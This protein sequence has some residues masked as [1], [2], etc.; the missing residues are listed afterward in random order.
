MEDQRRLH[1]RVGEEQGAV[2]EWERVAVGHGGTLTSMPRSF[3]RV[4][5]KLRLVGRH[6]F[7]RTGHLAGWPFPAVRRHRRRPARQGSRRVAQGGAFPR[8]RHALRR[9]ARRNSV[10]HTDLPR[11][12]D[13]PCRPSWC[14]HHVKN[15]TH[16]LASGKREE[17]FGPLGIT[18][19]GRAV[20]PENPTRVGVT[21]DVPDLEALQDRDAGAGRRRRDGARRRRPGHPGHPHRGVSPPVAP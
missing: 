13:R 6:R 9:Y 12:G 5:P 18:N 8:A 15:T 3:G 10:A 19:M 1:A 16:W 7:A 2:V 14:F 17:F 20:D 4:E 11:R 21:M